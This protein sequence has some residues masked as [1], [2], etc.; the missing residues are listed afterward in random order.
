[1]SSTFRAPYAEL[2]EGGDYYIEAN[3]GIRIYDDKGEVIPSAG[4]KAATLKGGLRTNFLGIVPLLNGRKEVVGSAEVTMVISAK[5]ENMPIEHINACG[6]HHAQ[7][8]R[9]YI[10]QFHREEYERDGVFTIY[11]YTVKSR[12]D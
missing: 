4:E 8:A 3:Y 10:M 2:G 9:E 12:N 5:P 6:F 1:M 11:Y 7:E